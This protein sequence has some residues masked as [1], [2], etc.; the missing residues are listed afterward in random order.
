M[1]G[2]LATMLPSVGA[3]QRALEYGQQA[4]AIARRL[5]EVQLL[6]MI[7]DGICFALQS[8][9]DAP[10]RLDYAQE[11]LESSNVADAKSGLEGLLDRQVAMGFALWWHLYSALQLGDVA[12]AKEDL[13]RFSLWAEDRREPFMMCLIKHF[14]GCEASLEGRFTD[15]ERFAQEALAIGQA[16]EVENAAG[17]LERKCLRCAESRAAYVKW[18]PYCAISSRLPKEHTPGVQAWR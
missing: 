9:L 17:I 5:G 6:P 2:A 15:F 8:P 16:L 13:G 10:Q 7:L 14:H 18:N 11:M 3:H 4:A 12:A 1:L